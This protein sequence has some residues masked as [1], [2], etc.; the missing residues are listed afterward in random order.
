M[1]EQQR[2]EQQRCERALAEVR[3][4]RGF[5]IHLIIY[6]SVN[7]GLLVIDWVTDP[8]GLTWFYFPLVGWGIALLIHAGIVFGAG[9]VLGAEWEQRKVRELMDQG[10]QHI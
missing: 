1:D 4:L 6:V 3:A 5:W 2:F 9:Q 10:R 7:L 8:P